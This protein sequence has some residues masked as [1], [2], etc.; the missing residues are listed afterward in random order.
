MPGIS[1]KE[2]AARD[3]YQ[4][5]V[6]TEPLSGPTIADTPAEELRRLQDDVQEEERKRRGKDS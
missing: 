5:H 3:A 6:V 1:P 2:R 4:P